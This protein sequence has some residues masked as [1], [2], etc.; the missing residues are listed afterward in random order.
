MFPGNFQGFASQSTPRKHL[1]TFQ[2]QWRRCVNGTQRTTL[3]HKANH[4]GALNIFSIASPLS[5]F[6]TLLSLAQSGT[7]VHGRMTG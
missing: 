1:Q 6:D 2:G 7:P 5:S 4:A 3:D